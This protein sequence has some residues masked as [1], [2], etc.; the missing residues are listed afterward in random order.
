MRCPQASELFESCVAMILVRNASTTDSTTLTIRDRELKRI[1]S[2]SVQH[3]GRI[4]E[5][6]A[7]RV[8]QQV[9]ERDTRLM[10]TH[11][12]FPLNRLSG[13]VENQTFCAAPFLQRSCS[14][15]HLGVKAKMLESISMER[16]WTTF[17]EMFGPAISRMFG[18]KIQTKE[19]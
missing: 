8:C 10:T 19:E 3:I 2:A 17:L 4:W 6:T 12:R 1:P 14:L 9:V 11:S 16:L 7:H 13:R 15:I 5:L 18:A